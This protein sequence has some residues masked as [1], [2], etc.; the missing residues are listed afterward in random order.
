MLPLNGAQS[1]N[2]QLQTD[3]EMKMMSEYT[4]VISSCDAEQII[5]YEIV[6]EGEFENNTF[7]NL[8]NDT[9]N[10]NQDSI[11]R[12]KMS[13]EELSTSSNK[14]QLLSDSELENKKLKYFEI[15]LPNNSYN[16]IQDSISICEMSKKDLSPLS[17]TNYISKVKNENTGMDHLIK[18][19]FDDTHEKN[20]RRIEAEIRL[21][22]AFR[23]CIIEMNSDLSIDEEDIFNNILK[24]LNENGSTTET[25]HKRKTLL[26]DEFD[27]DDDTDNISNDWSCDIQKEHSYFEKNNKKIIVNDKIDQYNAISEQ[28]PKS[29]QE[30]INGNGI[31]NNMCFDSCEIKDFTKTYKRFLQKSICLNLP[32]RIDKCIECRVHQTKNNLTKREYDTITCRF[33]A[34]REL[35][36]TKSGILAVAGYPDP[37]KNIGLIDMGMWLPGKHSAAPSDFNIKASTKILEDAGSQFCI[38]VRDEIEALNLNLPSNG[39]TRKI[40]WKKCVKGVREMCDVCK[41]TIFN[42]HWSCG[43]CG[44]VVC[45][46]CFRAKLK[47]TQLT[48][49]QSIIQR[50][51]NNKIWLLCSNQ[52]EHEVENLSITQ[53]LAGNALEYISDLM[54]DTCYS[55]NIPLNCNCEKSKKIVSPDYTDSALSEFL[56][57]VYGKSSSDDSDDTDDTDDIDDADDN[58]EQTLGMQDLIKKQ[59]F[60]YYNSMKGNEG[61][62]SDY[63][64]STSISRENIEDTFCKAKYIRKKKWFIPKISLLS[65]DKTHVPHM[66]LCEGHLLRLLDP[67]SD[68]NYT[69]F[70]EQWKRGQPVLVSDVGNKLSSSLWHPESFSRDFGDQINDLINCTT[71]NVIS[72]QPMSKFWNGFENAE[73]RLCDKHGNVM[74]LKLKDWPPSAD[75]AETLPDRFQDLMNCLPLK[76][77]T[78]RNGKYNLAS[79]LPECFVRPDLGPK[80]YTAYGNSSTKNKEVG[81]TNLHLDISDAVNVMVYVAITKNCKEY[82][83][84]WYVKEALQVIEEAGCDDLTMRRIYVDGE[85]PGALWHIYHASDADSIRDLLIKVSVE[86]GTPLEQFSDPIHDQSHYLD[87]YLRERLYREYGVKGYTIVQYYGDAVFIPAGAPHQVR[88]LHNCIKVAEDFVSPENVHHSFRMTQ[89]FRHLT[90][91]HTNHE[92]KLQ[93][94]NIVFH[95][96]KDSVSVLMHNI[97]RLI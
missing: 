53:I 19:E 87:E 59:H 14:N 47:G 31:H 94:K 92:D 66:W 60:N 12:C 20:K 18:S 15:N 93:I 41:T 38:F 91:S 79:R 62:K 97:P 17:N 37:F 5:E 7:T 73:E 95:A 6:T 32:S 81:T 84:N 51:F 22:N 50:N 16:D 71:G 33:Y 89:E 61:V 9:Y 63:K 4:E 3:I 2:L 74:L 57:K 21:E 35:K 68:I 29:C 72:D 85:I 82:D 58:E 55:R 25:N 46:D 40:V 75:F 34:F 76:E 23:E 42:H 28:S 30:I 52:K 88:N 65:D 27:T 10:D 48:E 24:Q 56:T 1:N 83:H 49:K 13:I 67:K 90:D 78:H 86:H 45:V 77:Y 43:K 39:K 36:Y 64:V 96:V 8:S 26:S 54:H 11:S 69:I 44:F 70:Q 80:M